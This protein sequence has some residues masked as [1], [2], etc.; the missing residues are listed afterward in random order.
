[1]RVTSAFAEVSTSSSLGFRSPSFQLSQPARPCE[2]PH[3][4]DSEIAGEYI[5]RGELLPECCKFGPSFRW[6]RRLAPAIVERPSGALGKQRISP[7]SD[8]TTQTEVL[9]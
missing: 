9:R 4:N 3:A 8:T 7:R 6:Q 1:Q 5:S 2:S